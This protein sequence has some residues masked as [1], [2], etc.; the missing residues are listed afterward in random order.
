MDRLSSLLALGE[1][2]DNEHFPDIKANVDK[3]QRLHTIETKTAL[4]IDEWAKLR[5]Y[6]TAVYGRIMVQ[7]DSY[8]KAVGV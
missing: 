2:M 4:G 8:L 7:L 1:M 5:S 6:K 3:W